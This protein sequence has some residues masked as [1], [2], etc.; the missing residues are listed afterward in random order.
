MKRIISLLLALLMCATLFGCGSTAATD[1][2]SNVEDGEKKPW[3]IALILPGV[4]SDNGWNAGAYGALTYLEDAIGAETAYNENTVNSDAEEV[5]RN[6]CSAGYNIIICHGSQFADQAMAVAPEF[7]N[8][9]FIL[10]STVMY[11][12]PNVCS[13]NLDYE[14]VGF[15]AGAMAALMSENGKVASMSG[16][17]LYANIH[18][19]VGFVNG[20]TYV[21]SDIDARTCYVEDTADLATAKELALAYI[22]EGVDVI[23]HGC[24]E[25]GLGVFEACEEKGIYAIGNVLDQR[26]SSSSVCTSIAQNLYSAIGILVENWWN[27]E[28]FVATSNLFGMKDGNVGMCPYSDA[29]PQEVIDRMNEIEAGLIDGS[30]D[31]T[32]GPGSELL[33]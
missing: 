1:D 14:Q 33:K 19:N 31:P 20:A 9:R 8:V 11:Q 22:A 12:E 15:L 25:A 10:N 27:G 23:R 7:E 24:N 18:A 21:N 30:I 16:P 29:V 32:Q 4:I 6:Y 3:K 17:E 5:I 26:D 13:L 2:V 28:E